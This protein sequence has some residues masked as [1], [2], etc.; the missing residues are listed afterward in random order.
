MRLISLRWLRRAW[1]GWWW[2]C[3]RV[4]RDVR[5]VHEP[6]PASIRGVGKEHTTKCRVKIVLFGLLLCGDLAVDPCCESVR[7]T[8]ESRL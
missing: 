8:E 5:M 3:H 4:L 7:S 6:P 2:R 1:P